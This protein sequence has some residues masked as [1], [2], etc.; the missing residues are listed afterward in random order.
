MNQR[1]LLLAAALAAVPVPVLAQAARDNI[2]A[3][4]EEQARAN[5]VPAAFVHQVVKRESNYNPNARGGSALGLMQIKHATARGLGYKGEASGLYDPKVNLRYGIAYLAGAYRTAKG[6]LAKAYHY[7][8]RGYYYAAKR[9][10]LTTEVVEAEAPAA[11]SASSFASVFALRPSQDPNLGAAS[12]ALA[13]AP[14]AAP[15]EVVEVPLPPRRPAAFAGQVQVAALASDLAGVSLAP[16]A[17][18]QA[19]AVTASEIAVVEVPL[20]PRRPAAFAALQAATLA[21]TPAPAATADLASLSLTPQSQPAA[22]QAQPAAAQ[23]QP[24]AAQAEPAGSAAASRRAVAAAEAI[25]VPLP[26]RRP[27]AQRLAAVSRPAAPKV[28]GVPVLEASALPP[29]Q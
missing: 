29:A 11:S 21:A 27:S 5:G 16:N 17:S 13:Y 1:L 15:T 19:V 26:P 20:P 2:D 24:A 25:E 18:Q 10:G 7:Y 4:I 23:A 14:T 22:A 6:D 28:A 9:Q 8:N 12:T 3:L